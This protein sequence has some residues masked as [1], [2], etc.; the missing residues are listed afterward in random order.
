[1]LK[2]VE[3][4][5]SKFFRLVALKLGLLNWKYLTVKTTYFLL[6]ARIFGWDCFWNL[7]RLFQVK[8][9]NSES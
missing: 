7:G 4:K 5:H 8:T 3:W 6:V 9:F 1:M 2:K